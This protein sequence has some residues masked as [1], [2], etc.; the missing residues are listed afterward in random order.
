M[1]R[2]DGGGRVD[3][4]A[5]VVLSSVLK[6]AVHGVEHLVGQEEEP[7]PGVRG[8]GSAVMSSSRSQGAQGLRR[9]A[10]PRRKGQ[11]CASTAHPTQTRCP[12]PRGAGASVGPWCDLVRVSSAPGVPCVV[13][14]GLLETPARKHPSLLEALFGALGIPAGTTWLSPN[15]AVVHVHTHPQLCTHTPSLP[16]QAP[17][18]SPTPSSKQRRM[19]TALALLPQPQRETG[20]LRRRGS[21]GIPSVVLPCGRTA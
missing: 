11:P 21:P 17:P 8:R 7:L 10:A 15:Q 14:E 12:S 1:V 9:E 4:Q 16:A 6:E 13:C 5:V 20:V 3:L 19:G 2:V 18:G